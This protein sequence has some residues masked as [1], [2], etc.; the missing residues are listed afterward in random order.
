V[1][2]H[3]YKTV[4]ITGSSTTDV[5]DAIRKAVARASQTLR[6]VEWLE[7]VSIRGYVRDGAVDHFQVTTKIGFKLE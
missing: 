7:V 6:N 5:S 2:N 1:S 4:E 3:V